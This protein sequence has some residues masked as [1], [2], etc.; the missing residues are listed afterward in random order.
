MAHITSK[1]FKN[2][3]AHVVEWINRNE[4]TGSANGLAKLILSLWSE[5]AAFSLSEC[6]SSFDDTRLA[7][8]EEK[9]LRP[10]YLV[11]LAD[12]EGTRF[13]DD[14]GY[15]TFWG[16]LGKEEAN[17]PIGERLKATEY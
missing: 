5:D 15:P 1:N 10:A 14:P 8:V 13:P 12:L 16:Q 2:P 11:Y 6:I 17:P 4:G 3:Y 7:W 9:R